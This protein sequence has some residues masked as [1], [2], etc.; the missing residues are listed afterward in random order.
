MRL[1]VGRRVEPFEHFDLLL[2]RPHLSHAE[3]EALRVLARR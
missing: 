1:E 2:C 3:A